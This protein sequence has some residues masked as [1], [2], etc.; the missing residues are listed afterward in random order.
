[1]SYRHSFFFRSK[2]EAEAALPVIDEYGKPLDRLINE[3][4]S[5]QAMYEVKILTEGKLTE[6]TTEI[7]VLHVQPEKCIVNRG[8]YEDVCSM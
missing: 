3:P 5:E 7:I 8:E 1:V 4:T 2:Q 6:I